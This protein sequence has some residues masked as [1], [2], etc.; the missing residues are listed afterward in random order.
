MHYQFYNEAMNLLRIAVVLSRPS[1]PGNIGA[2]A[3]AMKTMGL[4]DLRLVAPRRFPDPEAVA[5]A[6][7]GVDVLRAARVVASLEEALADRVLAVG[8]T[9]RSRELSL[10]VAPLRNCAPEIV[11]AAA[12]G[13]VALVFGNE[14]SGL[15]NEELGRCQRLATIPS[16][17]DYPS[18]NLAAAVQIACYE[19]ALAAHD[20]PPPAIRAH[21]PATGKDLEALFGHLEASMLSSGYLDPKRPGKLMERFRRLFGRSRLERSEVKALRGMLEAFE[22]KM[23]EARRR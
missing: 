15:S 21:L 16:S 6:A 18:L 22:R 10:P 3:R 2:A 14:T 11:A 23:Q 12:E 20:M 4:A 13:G 7:G 19:V 1:H 17:R 5:L 9:A 8:F